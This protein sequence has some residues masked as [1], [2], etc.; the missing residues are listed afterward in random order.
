MDDIIFNTFFGGELLY[1]FHKF[2]NIFCDLLL[3]SR[4][5]RAGLDVYDTI[6]KSK[7]MQNMRNMLI[8]RTRKYIHMNAEAA[9]FL[10]QVADVYI[11]SAG[12]LAAQ[13]GQGTGV[14][15]KHCNSKH[16]GFSTQPDAQRRI[17]LPCLAIIV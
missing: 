16:Q 13:S 14:V 7:M 10:R 2:W 11:H 8:L 5:L 6:A 1:A 9:K 15:R 3:C 12:I 4:I 17:N